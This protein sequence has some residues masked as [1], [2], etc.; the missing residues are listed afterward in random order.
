MFL[1]LPVLG[2]KRCSCMQPGGPARAT[3]V[4]GKSFIRGTSLPRVPGGCGL[5]PAPFIW[6]PA[7]PCWARSVHTHRVLVG[8]LC[9]GLLGRRASHP[10]WGAFAGWGRCGARLCQRGPAEPWPRPLQS[11]EAFVLRLP[12]SLPAFQELQPSLRCCVRSFLSA[13]SPRSGRGALSLARASP[14]RLVS[15][16]ERP[17]CSPTPKKR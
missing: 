13:A 17:S 4:T 5:G 3:G 1:L 14:A 10:S 12:L 15:A 11:C 9:Q 6:T 16:G 7:S 2:R 8:S